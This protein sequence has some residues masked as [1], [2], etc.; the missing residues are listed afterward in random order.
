MLPGPSS[1]ELHTIWVTEAE[2]AQ[3]HSCVFVATEMFD[4]NT[5]KEVS[6]NQTKKV[7]ELSTLI[8]L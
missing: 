8:G 3:R 7:L 5:C 6:Q 4:A 2:I 1:A